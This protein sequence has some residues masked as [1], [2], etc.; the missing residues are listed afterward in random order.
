MTVHAIGLRPALSTSSGLADLRAAIESRSPDAVLVQ[1]NLSGASGIDLVE[2][3]MRDD[4]DLVA[5]VVTRASD[6]DA[7]AQ[8]LSRV[9]P[10]RHVHKPFEA[11]DLLPKLRAGL[12]R[13]AL[14]REL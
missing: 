11:R 2:S 8:A 5:I 1:A 4:A 6:P 9:G 3:M 14:A 7:T 13:R 10:L 12:E